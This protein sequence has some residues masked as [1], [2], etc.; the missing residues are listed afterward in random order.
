[1]RH[2]SGPVASYTASKRVLE[3]LSAA[4]AGETKTFNVRVAN[5]RYSGTAAAGV[6]MLASAVTR[7]LK[8]R[9]TKPALHPNQGS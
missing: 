3:A 9:A 8:Q 1:M 4:L 2:P 5:N 6:D 7:K